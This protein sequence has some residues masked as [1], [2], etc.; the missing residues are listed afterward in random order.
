MSQDYQDLTSL[1]VE[2]ES[3]RPVEKAPVRFP[4]KP[5]WKPRLCP[6]RRLVLILLFLC[7][8]FS[9]VLLAFGV[10]GSN[11]SSQLWGFE[12]ILKSMNETVAGEMSNLQVKEAD[13]EGKITKMEGTVKQLTEEGNA[14]RSQLQGQVNEVQKN[15]RNMN[16]DLQN[17]KHNRTAGQEM[18]CPKDWSAFRK[19]CYWE[20]RAGKTWDEAK[21]DCESRDAHLVIINSYEEQLFIAVRVKPEF[22]WI[23]LTDA[24]GS[25]TWVDGTPYTIRQ[26][27]W[28]AEQPD[29]WYGH[30]LGGGED[31]AHLHRNGCW[32]DDH[33]SRQ[34]GWICEMETEG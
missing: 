11:Y 3:G 17:F 33:C 5:S 4:P 12:E 22:M 31:C 7:A 27:E 30:G 25:W 16:C 29:N 10:K 18:C 15:L 20:S 32:N 23:G 14:V 1:D 28:C 13:M 9:L 2:D 34:Y 24:T 26:E 6:S 19:N 21:E 8:I